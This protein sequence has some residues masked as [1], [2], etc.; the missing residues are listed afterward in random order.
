MTSSTD[1]DRQQSSVSMPSEGSEAVNLKSGVSLSIEL[2][3][4]I[5]FAMQQNE[6]PP[7]KSIRIKNRSDRSINNL[8]IVISSEPEFSKLWS[9]R[10]ETLLPGGAWEIGNIDILL[11]PDFLFSLTERLSGLLRIELRSNGET[12]ETCHEQVSLLAK[13]EWSGLNSLSELIAAFVTPNHPAVEQILRSA[14]R[15]LRE[16]TGDGALSGYQCKSP[17][18]VAQTTAAVYE[19]IAELDLNYIT[20]PASFE[21]E[22]QRIRLPDRILDAKMGTC[23]DLAVLSAACLEQAGLFP[24][25]VFIHGHAFAGVWL[26]DEC[27]PES[28]VTDPITL[29]KRV[30]LKEI[31][32]F[33]TTLVTHNPRKA[34]DLALVEGQRRLGNPAEFH[35]AVDVFRARKARIRPIPDRIDRI[36]NGNAGGLAP[37]S[38]SHSAPNLRN[39][40]PTNPENLNQSPPETPETRLDRWCRKL[41]DL[42]LRNPLINLRL[43][44]KTIP[45]CCADLPELENRLADEKNISLQP[46]PTEF[47]DDSPRSKEAFIIRHG[48][49][50]LLKLLQDEMQHN[51]LYA[52]LKGNDF[53]LNLVETYRA[54]RL[55]IEEGGSSS[56]YLAL[57]MLVWYETLTSGQPRMAPILLLP[58]ELNRKTVQSGFTF[59]VADEEPRINVTLLEML[60][61]DYELD[62]TGLDELPTDDRGLDVARIFKRFREAIKTI[63]RWDVEEMAVIGLFSFN[64]Y[65]MWRDLAENT[66]KLLSNEIVSHL[67]NRPDREFSPGA[68][69]PDP[70]RLDDERRLTE[71][72]CPVSSDSSQLSAIYAA[73]DGRSFVLEGP[74]GTGKSQTITNLIAQCLATGKTVLFV[75]EKMAALDVVKSRLDNVGLGQFCLELHSNKSN[76]AHVLEQL[77]EGLSAGGV[78]AEKEWSDEAIR[79]EKLRHDLNA[80]VFALHKPRNLGQPLYKMLARLVAMSGGIDVELRWE[81]A[82]SI[83]NAR[84]QQLEETVE[85]LKSAY[86]GVQDAKAHPWRFVK[87]SDWSPQFRDR[88]KTDTATVGKTVT[89]LEPCVQ[90]TA[91]SLK[92]NGADL[93][94]AEL[95]IFNDVASL[96]LDTPLIPKATILEP[97]WKTLRDKISGWVLTGR[98]YSETLKQT[99]QIFS[100]EILDLDLRD[101]QKRLQSARNVW[102]PKSWWE[103]RKIKKQLALC[104]KGNTQPTDADIDSVLDIAAQCRENR[105]SIRTQNE[106]ASRILGNVWNCS[107]SDWGKIEECRDWI[108]RFRQLSFQ[109]TSE[110]ADP[111]R[112]NE[113]RADWASLVVDG[114]EFLSEQGKIG[115]T[116]KRFRDRY[117]SFS[118]SLKQLALSSGATVEELSSYETPANC[119]GSVRRLVTNIAPASELLKDWC[120]WSRVR[121]K[122]INQGLAPLVE[123]LEDG[124]IIAAQVGPAFAGNF[125]RWWVESVVE[126]EPVLREFA[127]SEHERR[128]ARFRDGDQKYL[129]LTHKVVANKLAARAAGVRADDNLDSQ[130]GIL[131]REL[132]KKKRHIPIR[133]LF[134][135]MPALLTRIKPCVLMSPMSVA[136]YLDAKQVRF[137]LVVFDEASQIPPW[138]AIGAIG[139]GKQAVI[140]GDPKQLPPTNFFMR[141]DSG[142]EVEEDD[143]A[144]DLE[145]ILDE[146]LAARL[147]TRRLNWHYRSRHES[148]IAFSNRQYYDNRLLIFPAAQRSGLGVSWRYVGG[149]YDKGGSRTNRL[150]ADA[151]VTEIVARLLDESRNGDSVGVV[152]F[153]QAQ[154]ALIEDLLDAKRME[155]PAIEP[156]FAEDNPNRV[157]V[158]NLEN[159]QGDERD[160]I[161]FSIC[162]G[163]D[164]S[165]KSSMN[166]GPMN[167][168]GGER[169]LNVAI[170]RSRREVIVFSSLEPDKIDLSRTRA[171]GVRDLKTFL[172]YSKRGMA[173]IGEVVHLNP[174]ADFDSPFEKLVYDKLV[175]LGHEVHL[176]VGCAGYRIDLAVV[177]P[178]NPGRYLIGIECD[179]ANYHRA[180][181]ARDRDRLR[182]AVLRDLGW[183]IHRI[184]ST[185]W[186]QK[187]QNEMAKVVSAIEKARSNARPNSAPQ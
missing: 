75:S 166:F 12:I 54:A 137:D 40:L 93:S 143:L 185:D 186:W 69:F 165:G 178:K 104:S 159:V 77:R 56:L 85:E 158:K 71:T 153:N 103:K 125:A 18:R 91:E 83:D 32:V 110:N 106:Y 6:I 176:Q 34:F 47:S 179:G 1:A 117:A 7:I 133:Q 174:N 109:I 19:S 33:E 112:L 150:E 134:N 173:A 180:K 169:R 102:W 135:R 126:Q 61:K 149:S 184:W 167:K 148:L 114:R 128:I 95:G 120:N 4:R 119:I 79:L 68:T 25:V 98:K 73:S 88:L 172:E 65:L 99:Q 23:L 28:A 129:A 53:E 89:D 152:T 163:P 113:I 86:E 9:S 72:Y 43:T 116:L 27:F 131:E 118:A 74:P 20:P 44:R 123:A 151:I 10:L 175:A 37:S 16:W 70:E 51:R 183:E 63:P 170:T 48:S 147:P 161:L 144:E 122:S 142:D 78:A 130:L 66:D 13:D 140:V 8:E 82:D 17:E 107:E 127:G 105:E 87:Q 39:F 136:Q 36:E 141:D 108:D 67:V 164:Q 49:D 111:S 90:V 171:R 42:S 11:Q 101:I 21:I 160:V 157:F 24:L 22:G 60:K 59:K 35:C 139:R 162:Y 94:W 168:D 46:F 121:S 115:N 132:A 62:V 187:P 124:R 100:A 76:K 80:Y 45:L 41:L 97:D 181:T 57:G 96:F 155:H 3:R 146:C 64:K 92:V 52:N 156:H 29:R 182:E 84:Y 58:I 145:S 55:G 38:G 15:K 81:G 5:N 2:D 26:L 14:S 154:Q 30:D 177:D 50:P 31:L 138:D